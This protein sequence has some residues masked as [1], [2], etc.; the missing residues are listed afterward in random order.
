MAG[1]KN[2]QQPITRED[3]QLLAHAEVCDL[4][5]L[6]TQTLYN[7]RCAGRGPRYLRRGHY[8]RYRLRDI[9]EW[10]TTHLE[11][12]DPLTL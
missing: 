4:L 12:I 9:L 8:I 5:G 1:R 2:N 3:V 6:S 7:W 10:Q 11:P